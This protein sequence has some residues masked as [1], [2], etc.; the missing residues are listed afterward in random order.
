MRTVCRITL[1]VLAGLVAH[2]LW[3]AIDVHGYTI[4]YV[5]MYLDI[6]LGSLPYIWRLA[7]AGT[8]AYTLIGLLAAL[9]ANE[10][11]AHYAPGQQE[12]L[13]RRCGFVLRGIS[14]P[15]CPECGERL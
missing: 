1:S 15:Q 4:M 8:L 6:A 11:F 10:L 7:V 9:T 2:I 14:E 3:R 12:T 13:C 5:M